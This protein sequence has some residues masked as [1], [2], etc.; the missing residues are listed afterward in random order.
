MTVRRIHAWPPRPAPEPEHWSERAAC[1]GVDLA[2]F[3]PPS[4]GS[5]TS[6]PALR[7]CASCPVRQECL[8]DALAVEVTSSYQ[9]VWGVR[10]GMTEPER[11]EYVRKL[12]R[13]YRQQQKASA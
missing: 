1:Q 13:E 11:L 4:G 10:G 9:C 3:F 8:D 6:R 12:R 7:I 2:V 5:Q